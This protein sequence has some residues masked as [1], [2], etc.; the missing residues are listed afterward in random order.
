MDGWPLAVS[1]GP[2]E[3]LGHVGRY[4]GEVKPHTEVTSS[5][6][7]RVT[8]E[9]FTELVGD[10]TYFRA[11]GYQIYAACQRSQ[12]VNSHAD[13]ALRCGGTSP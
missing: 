3:A 10:R 5:L 9:G 7:S 2:C 11:F 6:A 13:R 8:L 4:T 1:E 12:A